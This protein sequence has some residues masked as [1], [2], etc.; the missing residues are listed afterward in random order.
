M[1]ASRRLAAQQA[2]HTRWS[3]TPDRAGALAPARRGLLDK[4]EKQV[5]PD[6]KLSAGDRQLLAESARKAFYASM[7]RKSVAA[8]KRNKRGAA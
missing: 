6:G 8:R 7:A 3:Q 1:S 2:A 5:D 4:F